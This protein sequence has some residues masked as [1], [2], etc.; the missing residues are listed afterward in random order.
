[1]LYINFKGSIFRYLGA[2]LKLKTH[3]AK[4]DNK[5]RISRNF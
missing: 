2:K 1:L 4:T 5:N 3:A